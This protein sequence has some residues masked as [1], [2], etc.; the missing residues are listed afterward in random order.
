M[1]EKENCHCRG[2]D[3]VFSQNKNH[4]RT[5]GWVYTCCPSLYH[6]KLWKSVECIHAF[7]GAV[8]VR[9][10]HIELLL[11]NFIRIAAEVIAVFLDKGADGSLVFVGCHLSL[12]L[13]R[14]IRTADPTGL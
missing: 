9:G 12:D 7:I 4:K 14:D 1:P 11:E 2:M 5:A 8:G 3:M 13:N 10:Q 6:K